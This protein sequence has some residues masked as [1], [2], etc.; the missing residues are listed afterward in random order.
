M[1]VRFLGVWGRWRQTGVCSSLFT[2][3]VL[4]VLNLCPGLGVG[5]C[6]PL[7]FDCYFVLRCLMWAGPKIL[8]LIH[9]SPKYLLI[10]LLAVVWLLFVGMRDFGL[11]VA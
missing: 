1:A 6:P 5:G 2:S 8:V 3:L 10:F 7:I 11:F 4:H 9:L